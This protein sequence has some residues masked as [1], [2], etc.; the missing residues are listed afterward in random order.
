MTTRARLLAPPLLFPQAVFAKLGDGTTEAVSAGSIV[1]MV[2]G[3]AIVLAVLIGGALLVRRLGKFPAAVDS[4]LKVI[5]G[6]SLTPR[7]R[8]VVVQV[9]DKQLLL[10]LSPGRIQTLH[11]LEQPLDISGTSASGLNALTQRFSALLQS[12]MK[13]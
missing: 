2:V 8:L 11:V 4:P 6:L 10:G 7:D 12:Q 9:G 5:T 3:L 13:K 1:Q